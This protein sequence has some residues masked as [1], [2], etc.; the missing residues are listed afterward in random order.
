MCVTTFME[1]SI[2]RACLLKQRHQISREGNFEQANAV[3]YE[4]NDKTDEDFSNLFCINSV[5]TN[6]PLHVD[7]LVD[8]VPIVFHLDI[9]AGVSLMSKNDFDKHFGNTTL[10]PTSVNYVLIRGYEAHIRIEEDA[11]PVF[12][13]A[14]PLPFADKERIEAELQKLES[15]EIIEKVVHSDWAAPIVPIVKPTGAIRLCGDYKVTVNTVSKP[16]KYPLPKA[17]HQI[18]LDEASKKLTTINT[19]VGLYQYNRLPYGVSCA[20]IL[21]QLTMENVLKGIDGVSVY[22]DDILVTG[23]DDAEHLSNLRAVMNRLQEYGLHLLKT[24]CKFMLAEVEYLG[25]K[26]S[27]DGVKPTESKAEAIKKAAFIGLVNYYSRFLPNLAHHMASLYLLLKKDQPWTWGQKQQTLFQEIEMMMTDD[28]TLAHYDPDVELVFLCDASASGIGAV[29]HQPDLNGPWK[30]L[31]VDYAGPYMGS[32]FL[33]VID[34]YSKWLEVL[35]V[36]S[37]N[38]KA[39]ISHLEKLFTNFGPPKHIVSDNGPQFASNEF[40]DFLKKHGIR[41]T[42]TPL[43]HPA[44]NG[45]AERYVRFSVGDKVYVLNLRAG[46]RWLPGIVI[47]VLQR[48]YFV[49]VEGYPVWKRHEAKKKPC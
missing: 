1:V 5:G 39:T 33:V 30:R 17:Y 49:H 3:D 4:V 28:V 2:E 37:T 9:G 41:H 46:P 13:K 32:M 43:R 48:S 26:I 18:P 31:H 38:S 36:K 34:S 12:S 8:D 15:Q 23:R 25:Y 44:S 16:D 11:K 10:S 27:K 7:V 19:H 45:M 35:P 24:K 22:L 6:P 42:L 21:F 29:L 20:V 47:E 14:R 40:G